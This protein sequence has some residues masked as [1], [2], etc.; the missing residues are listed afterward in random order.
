M[1]WERNSSR[2][3]VRAPSGAR[4]PIRGTMLG[5][6]TSGWWAR[7]SA[8]SAWASTL[9]ATTTGPSQTPTSS[10]AQP[11]IG[12][13][14]P[15]SVPPVSRTT[16]GSLAGTP[17][18]SSPRP[19]ANT[20]TTLPPLD[21]ATRRPASAVTSSSLPTTA[22]RRPPPA[23][24]QASVGASTERAS[25]PAI[26]AR[27]AS[28]PSRTS[29]SMVVGCSADARTRPSSRSTSRAL[30]NVDPKS[31]QITA[32]TTPPV[33]G[34]GTVQVRDEVVGGLDADAEPDQV[35]GNLQ[36]GAGHAQVG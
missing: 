1:T 31:T 23:L 16:S 5:A 28:Y 35:G 6:T 15:P 26:F 27:Q 9:P 17:A 18:R 8:T 20:A 30:V 10:R 11:R 33:S 19:A 2:M 29:V 34:E 32:A 14:L 3:A 36:L 7:T 13:G 4:T 21:R 24:E 22:I 25:C 12:S